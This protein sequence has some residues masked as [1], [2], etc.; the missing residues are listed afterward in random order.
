MVTCPGGRSRLIMVP[1][2]RTTK[3]GLKKQIRGY[4]SNGVERF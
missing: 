2:F 1:G 3:R 4:G